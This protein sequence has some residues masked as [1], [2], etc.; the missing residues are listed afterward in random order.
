MAAAFLIVLAPNLW[1]L[2]GHD[3]LPLRYVDA[4]A[5]TATHWYQYLIFPLRW[6]VSQIFFLLPTIAMLALLFTGRRVERRTEI[7]PFARRYV[8]ALALGPFLVTTA[9]AALLGRLPVS[10]WGY[11]LWSLAPLAVL[12]WFRPGFADLALRRFV[13]TAA[14]IVVVLP[15]IYGLV[16]L[17]APLLRDRPK[18]TYFPGRD[19][20]RIVTQQWRDKTGTALRYVGGIAAGHG[21]GEFAA[22]NVAVYSPD[23]PHVIVHGNRRFSPWIDPA[24]LR[25][26]GAVLIWQQAPGATVLPP[27]IRRNYPRAELQPQLVLPS[28]NPFSRL[29]VSVTYGF[30]PPQP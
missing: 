26:H 16:E 30:V 20:A 25:R 19:M 8:T 13:V 15:A 21:P 17:F 6:T 22:N 9:I 27:D 7:A 23:R 1:W 3:F 4:R 5:A 12:L 11:P 14:A 29:S 24:D 18:A 2:A 10:L 28:K